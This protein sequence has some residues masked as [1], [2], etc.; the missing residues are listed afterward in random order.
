MYGP[1]TTLKMEQWY[2]PQGG[3]GRWERGEQC[4]RQVRI[5]CRRCSPAWGEF[6]SIIVIVTKM[7][8]S[9][10]WVW[11]HHNQDVLQL[12]VSSTSSSLSPRCSPAGEEQFASTDLRCISK[13]QT[14]SYHY[15]HF[16]LLWM[17]RSW[18]EGRWSGWRCWHNGTPTC[19]A[20]IERWR[21]W[22]W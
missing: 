4:H 3:R 20:I 13:T 14:N 1:M 5:P 2:F 7:F 9:L 16:R 10:R 18:E 8:C 15:Y 12:G 21:W 19:C 11:H 17:W 22:S 6:N